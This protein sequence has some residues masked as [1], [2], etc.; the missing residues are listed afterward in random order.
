M[1]D[2]STLLL[3]APL[4][5]LLQVLV[6]YLSNPVRKI[7]AAHPL[8]PFTSLWISS[9]RWR[10]IE[11][12][13]L[14]TAHDRLGP[15]ICL[16]PQE[17]SVNCVKG[18]IRDVYAGGFEKRDAKSGYNWYGFFTNFGTP[19]MFSTGMN[20][21]HSLRKRM[22]SNIYS[23]SVV[24]AS[25]VLQAQVSTILYQRLLPRLASIYSGAGKGVF[26]VSSLISASTMDIVTSY[27]F[28]LKASSNLLDDPDQLT[29]F[30]G[31]YKS[32]HG[33]TFWP[34]EFP[35]LTGFLRKWLGIRLS[36]K[37]VDTAN[38]EIEQ[39]TRNMCDCAALVVQQGRA[40]T[41]EVPSV[42]QQLSAAVAKEAKK[43]D[44]GEVDLRSVI[45]SEVLDHL[46]AG[47]D[48]SA[49]TLTYVVHELSTHK[50]VQSRLQQEL[51]NI[52][53]RLNTS[54]SPD[55][56]DPK[57]MDALPV[58]HAVIWETLRLHSAIP[59]PQP[60]YTPPQGCQLGPSGEYFVPGGVRVSASAGIL[61][62]N[63]DVYN[64]ASEWRPERWLNLEKLDEEKRKDMETRWFWAFGS[65]GRMCVGSHL[66][67]YQ[68]KYIVAA[69]YSNYST[70][71]VN[72]AGIEQSDSYTAPP[73]GDKLV[74]KLEKLES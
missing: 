48:T 18:G 5:L 56:P 11:N 60:R 54:S 53:P 55:L 39:W 15:I 40:K 38:A 45:A 64:C 73:K 46:A 66:A 2:L 12:A 13:T 32:R 44:V 31:L 25:P 57:V 23:K 1:F 17:I 14:K 21:P 6:S 28:G 49:I 33:W 51:L 67:V 24:V 36:P 22:L 68:M 8:A 30:L 20:K 4:G 41:E 35:W 19:N 61:H 26:E 3:L 50:E 74:I 72:D 42:Y 47:F 29:W 58:L 10:K 62:Q 34:Q 27:I 16:G 52:S 65:G 70:S 37:W 71:V 63:E 7:P 69:L 43:N 59:G 9:I